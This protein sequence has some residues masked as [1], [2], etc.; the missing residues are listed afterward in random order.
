MCWLSWNLETSSYWNTQG[1]SCPVQALPVAFLPRLLWD[2]RDL[3]KRRYKCINNNGHLWNFIKIGIGKNIVFLWLNERACAEKMALLKLKCGLVNSLYYESLEVFFFVA[4]CLR[5]PLVW[6]MT[7]RQWRNPHSVT[8]RQMEGE[9][10]SSIL[11]V[12]SHHNPFPVL[13]R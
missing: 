7:L 6:D 12:T 3:G 13:F 1:L 8:L 11:F 2:L 9:V 4:V 5:S 10:D